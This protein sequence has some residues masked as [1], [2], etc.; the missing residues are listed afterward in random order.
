MRRRKGR[1][2]QKMYAGSCLFR[3]L[4]SGFVAAGA[5]LRMKK[6]VCYIGFL[7]T[8]EYKALHGEVEEHHAWVHVL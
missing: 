7:F 1:G 4:L 5:Q 8:D 3:S 6:E 2:A